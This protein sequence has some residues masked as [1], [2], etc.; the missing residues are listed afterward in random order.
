MR[1]LSRVLTLLALP[2]TLHAQTPPRLDTMKV[3]DHTRTLVGGVRGGFYERQYKGFGHFFDST[4][5][6]KNGAPRV[7]DL[8]QTQQGINLTRPPM[9]TG[10]GAPNDPNV[11]HNNCVS[12]VSTRVAVTHGLCAMKILLDGN[13]IATGGEIDT[14]DERFDH[15]HSWVTAFDIT[16]IDLGS[17]DKVEIYR[18]T[19]EI[20]LELKGGDTECGLVVLWGRQ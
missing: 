20:P 15:R 14:R 7:A 8:L 11:H 17:L 16:T 3:I 19:E 10:A 9:C 4:D 1:V 2:V 5:L 12:S 13:A 18:R 6:R